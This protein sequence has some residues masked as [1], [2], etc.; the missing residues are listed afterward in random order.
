MNRSHFKQVNLADFYIFQKASGTPRSHAFTE[1]G[2]W[3]AS[4]RPDWMNLN[5]EWIDPL[6][7]EDTDGKMTSFKDKILDLNYRR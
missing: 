7:E 6:R 5:Q 2:G 4:I 1:L 3:E